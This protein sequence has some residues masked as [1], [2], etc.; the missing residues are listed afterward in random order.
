MPPSIVIITYSVQDSFDRVFSEEH[1]PGWIAVDTALSDSKLSNLT[2][3]IIRTTYDHP[4]DEKVHVVFQKWLPKSYQR[5]ILWWGLRKGNNGM[6][7]LVNH[8]QFTDLQ[9]PVTA[10]QMSQF[11]TTRSV[12]NQFS[13]PYRRYQSGFRGISLVD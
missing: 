11:T 5:G 7:K 12:P 13:E 6:C 4:K 3:F 8:S 9:V 1:T 2:H 10:S